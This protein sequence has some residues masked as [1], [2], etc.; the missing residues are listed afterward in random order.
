MA[1]T[2]ASPLRQRPIGRASTFAEVS[3][4]LRH[5][6]SST[7]SE[8]V[9]DAKQSIK[10]STDD[11]LL[12]RIRSGGLP[13]QLEPSHWHSTPL[14]L[15]LLPAI[16]GILFKN[17]SAVVTDI[18]LLGLAAIFLNWSV[19]LPW[20]VVLCYL[21]LPSVSPNYGVGSG[22]ILPSIC[23]R[24]SLDRLDVNG[25]RTPLWK[26]MRKTTRILK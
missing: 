20:Y 6:R 16:G 3:S 17:G 7:F 2:S 21:S 12:P 26:K 9:D 19:R 1:R 5:R 8:S 11:L 22:T 13:S 23:K 25:Q 15:A 24:R 10:S 18:T 4:P 14:A